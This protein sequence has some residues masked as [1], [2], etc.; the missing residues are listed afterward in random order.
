MRQHRSFPRCVLFCGFLLSAA[1]TLSAQ[2]ESVPDS[3]TSRVSLG[4]R[5]GY[6]WPV[7]EWMQHRFAPVDQ[8]DAGLSFGGDIEIRLSEKGYLA[9]LVDHTQ[10]D[11]SAWEDYAASQGSVVDAS[12]SIT[13]LGLAMRVN[14]MDT[15]SSSALKLDIGALVALQTGQE[16]TGRYSYEYD[17]MKNPAFG[18]FGALEY[19]Y[20]FSPKVGLTLRGSIAFV[21]SGIDYADGIEYIVMLAPVTGGLR[22]YL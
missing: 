6:A 15:G 7:G 12:A 17:F 5:A 21:L 1:G 4:L 19:V 14:L 8:F 13:Q 2:E 22:F 10:L 20:L 3:S 9:I 11:V 18:L 16:T